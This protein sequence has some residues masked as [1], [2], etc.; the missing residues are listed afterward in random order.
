[1]LASELGLELLPALSTGHPRALH[2]VGG[3][4]VHLKAAVP[5]SLRVP[6]G[7]YD[8]GQRVHQ[9]LPLFRL[10]LV[11]GPV[12]AG[13]GEGIGAVSKGAV[14][15]RRGAGLCRGFIATAVVACTAVVRQCLETM[16]WLGN[17][18]QDVCPIRGRSSG[19][20]LPQEILGCSS[21]RVCNFGRQRRIPVH[22]VFI[23]IDD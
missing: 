6:E 9:E 19:L 5:G 7:G 2:S 3:R 11:A 8:G 10:G 16:Y 18:L 13:H 17:R 1:M 20:Q 23:S 15:C 12:A 21:L 22:F 14:L 4:K